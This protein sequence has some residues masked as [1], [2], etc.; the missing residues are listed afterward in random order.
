MR[1]IVV[2]DNI[3]FCDYICNFLQNADYQTVKAY[4]L[5]QARQVIARSV[6]ED[7]I[8][9]ADLRLPDGESTALLEWMR[10]QGYTHPFI[11]MTNYEEIHTAVHV[12]K[13]GAE[14]YILKPLLEDKLLPALKKIRMADE[15]FAKVI[16]ERKSAAFRELDRYIRLVAPTDMT[17][18]ILGNTG[19]GKEHL[20]GKI[21]KRSLRANKPYITVDCGSLSRELAASAFFGHVKGAFTG[22]TDEKPGYFQEARGGTL[23]LDEVEN[24]P[25]EIQQMLLRA[26]EER[27]YRPVGGRQDKRMDVRVIAATNE[28]L[29][30][31][32]AEKRFRKD[33]LYRLQ[34]FTITVPTLQDCLE[35]ILPLADFFRIQSAGQLG[36]EIP[37]F[38]EAAKKIL[39]GY[40]WPG[41]V[42]ELKQVVHVAVLICGG[43]LITPQCLRLQQADTSNILGG[44][45]SL[46]KPVPHLIPT[47]NIGKGNGKIIFSV[48]LEGSLPAY[49]P[50]RFHINTPF[51]QISKQYTVGKRP[52]FQLLK[53]GCRLFHRAGDCNRFQ[54]RPFIFNTPQ[55]MTYIICPVNFLSQGN[56]ISAL[57]QTEVIPQFFPE[58]NL[59]G[60]LL[61]CPERRL[62]PHTV[63][64]LYDRMMPQSS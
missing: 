28:D 18:L 48:P 25:V 52:D 31:A 61:F 50:R 42:R 21:H 56:N 46:K 43:K 5:A 27:R 36:K 3:L 22:A 33:L 58:I 32:V 49:F 47:G 4:R 53:G 8:V 29:Q 51:F 13:L 35:D 64:T 55:H 44:D 62:V 41:N 9:L 40:G 34:D 59:E 10:G 11:V 2:E 57:P 7:D 14:D 60:S 63:P 38:D 24:L 16:Y 30:G 37:D 1:V 15:A 12:M 45:T 54:N 6:R 17:V 19:T 39:L 20:A 26:M 23:F